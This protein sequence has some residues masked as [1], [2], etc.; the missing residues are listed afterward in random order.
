M[1]KSCC[2]T[3]TEVSSCS[4]DMP[5]IKVAIVEDDPEFRCRFACI[6][7]AASSL[8]L[9]G[10][11]ATAKEG[12]A[13][14][15]RGE[16]EIYLV[17]LGLPDEN[18]IGLIRYITEHQPEAD[19]MVVTVFGDDY[20]V[21][22]SIQAGAAGYLLKDALPGEMVDC[23]RELHDGGSPVSPVIARRLLRLFRTAS[24]QPASAAET[25]LSAREAETLT[26]VAKGMS[27]AEIGKSLAISPHTVR[28]HVRKIYEKLAVHSR[29]EAVFEARQ[30]GL[31]R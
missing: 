1:N 9:V 24:P 19:A 12:Y 4:N 3:V 7:D 25:P 16:A 18:G 17:D 22:R 23:I 11:A 20:H 2:E 30:M 6:V 13:L 14:I 31:L 29:G 26:L 28:A 27:F 15:D 5:P 8:V 10:T 21:I